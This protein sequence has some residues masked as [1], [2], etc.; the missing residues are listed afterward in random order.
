MISLY[1]KELLLRGLSEDR[2]SLDWSARSLADQR[3]KI[4][5]AT[6]IAKSE[7]VWAGESASFALK[8]LATD[9]GLP[10]TV[11]NHLLNGAR[12]KSRTPLVQ[13]QGPAQAILTL[14]RTWINLVAYA[15][16]IATQTRTLVDA[17]QKC[18]LSHSPRIT[19][20]RKILPGY[21]ELAIESMILGG[22]LP[23][24]PALDSGILIKENH[25]ASHGSI[26]AAIK[27]ARSTGP[28]LH[29]IEIE[30]RNTQELRE[31]IEAG[32]EVIMLDNFS[33]ATIHEAIALKPKQV[34]YEVSG[35]VNIKNIQQYAIE[36]IDI[37]SVGSLTHSVV[38]CDFSLLHDSIR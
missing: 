3:N 25:I 2:A 19:G 29:K 38:S 36:G 23:H 35:G 14:E 9:L 10:L 11:Q 22:G 13:I 6:L 17:V 20:T 7:G 37:I 34:Q 8:S 18:G 24:R 31:A 28:H 26:T 4:I 32:A 16:G 30:V 15:S 33:T 12:F 21:R 1:W 27:S 5:S